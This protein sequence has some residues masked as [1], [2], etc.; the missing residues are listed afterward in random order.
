ML[1]ILRLLFLHKA[2]LAWLASPDRLDR[3]RWIHELTARRKRPLLDVSFRSSTP[4]AYQPP[5]DRLPR[6]E[7]AM[8]L[9]DS[10]SDFL[11]ARSGDFV[12]LQESEDRFG[13]GPILLLY[14]VPSGIDDEE[15]VEMVS[16]GAPSLLN[17]E[18]ACIICR[19]DAQSPELDLSMQEALEAQVREWS[20]GTG[21]D[22][23][24]ASVLDHTSFAK[25]SLPIQSVPTVSAVP[26]LLFSGFVNSEMLSVYNIIGKEIYD[27]TAGAVSPACAKA[28]PNAMEK[29][30]RQVLSEIA[31]DHQD[32]MRID[33]ED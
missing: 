2:A 15:L 8:G 7:L 29:P 24:F 6:S 30:L 22:V 31:G 17:K 21:P 26:V 19:L 32:A 25:L 5:A 12:K 3:G 10:L 20:G 1:R 13:P 9:L 18:D 23:S 28:V 11:Q 14:N 27:E 4:I 33:K 16:D